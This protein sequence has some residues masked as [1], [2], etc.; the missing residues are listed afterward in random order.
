MDALQSH[1]LWLPIVAV[2]LVFSLLRPLQQGP[3]VSWHVTP[4]FVWVALIAATPFLAN[5]L[6][7]K[8]KRRTRELIGGS[9]PSA[10]PPTFEPDRGWAVLWL[11]AAP[12]TAFVGYRLYVGN[13]PAQLDAV[14]VELSGRSQQ[15]QF[16]PPVDLGLA[17]VWDAAFIVGYGTALWMAVVAASWVFWT[18]SA[19]AV[20]RFAKP[21]VAVAVTADLVENALLAW[22]WRT[23]TPLVLEVLDAASVAAR[24][25]FAMIVPA[26]LVAAT[27]VLVAA[28]RLVTGRLSPRA[29]VWARIDGQQLRTPR[30]LEVA[31]DSAP[32]PPAGEVDAPPGGKAQER[33]AAAYEVPDVK[34]DGDGTA[35]CLSGGGVRSAC[36]SLGVLDSL[37]SQLANVRYV[38]AVSGGSYTAGAVSQLLSAAPHGT[39]KKG[40]TVEG[41]FG[42]AYAPGSVELDH[43]R[44][45]ASYI[46]STP[47]EMI[48][49]LGVLARGLLASLALLFAPAVLLGILVAFLYHAVP[50]AVL[51][52]LSGTTETSTA[53]ATTSQAVDKGLLVT[54]QAAWTALIV[55]A[56]ALIAW[57]VQLVWQARRPDAMGRPR[58]STRPKRAAVFATQTAVVVVVAVLGIPVLLWLAVWVADKVT[59]RVHIGVGSAVG[60]VLLTYAASL[61]ALLWRKRTTISGALTKRKRKGDDTGRTA[62]AVPRGLLQLLLVV[63]ASAV[64][65]AGWLLLFGVSASST[66]T[67]L[68]AC[69]HIPSLQG[70]DRNTPF[71]TAAVIAL[72]VAVLGALLDEASLSLHPFYRQR[73][74]SA[75]ATRRLSADGVR[76]YAR[77]YEPQVPTTLSAYTGSRPEHEGPTFVYGAAANLN[78]D[79]RTPRGLNCMSFTFSSDWCGGPDIGWVQTKSLEAVV[80]SRLRRDVTVQGAVAI[81]GAAVASAMGRNSGW[82]SVFLAVTGVR[83]GAWLPNPSFL[84]QMHAA[85]TRDGKVSDWTLPGL[86]RVRRMTYL[87]REVFGRHSASDRLILV[88][89]GGHYENL[90]L[91]EA[92]RRRCTTIY[93]ADG[94]GDTPPT[95]QGLVEAINLAYAELGVEITLDDPLASEPGIGDPLRPEAPLKTLNAALSRTPVV[96]GTIKYPEAAGLPQGKDVGRLYVMRS[97]LWPSMPYSLLSYAARHPEFPRDSTGDQWFDDGQFSAY[98]MLGRA[99]GDELTKVLGARPPWP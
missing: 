66:V 17:L 68:N 62:A 27:G 82:Y 6:V 98:F 78:S 63:L 52:T 48:I 60:S 67:S 79:H 26:V 43:L 8:R 73:L 9:V 36:V 95:A 72:F 38:I 64:L 69:D 92:L 70:C 39:L 23:G 83:L 37:R 91:V 5:P 75:F 29:A 99:M 46:T 88:S 19:A 71:Y 47:R 1:R 86:P 80:S 4:S 31:A 20:A 11:A 85:R 7:R 24:I 25:K 90:G 54:P 16:P 87:L 22:A 55:T 81:S 44:R 30:P 3:L 76:T 96:T 45:H 18:P 65:Y 50:I 97:T 34:L 32:P 21:C 2:A 14:A 74:A 58:R 15:Q 40:E 61:A 49:A 28:V 93:L 77:A 84:A 35:F 56:V 51:P 42:D 89:D 12:V 13:A 53:G 59:P 94:G 10:A 33:W 41:A 57:L